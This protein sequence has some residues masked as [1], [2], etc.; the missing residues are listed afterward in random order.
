MAR[1]PASVHAKLL[2]AF[3]VI[4]GLLVTVSAVGRVLG[5]TNRRAEELVILHRKIAAYRQ[6]Q[7]DTTGQLYSVTSTLALPLEQVDVRMIE[8][9]LRQ[10]KQFGYDLDRLQY[11]AKDEAT[12]LSRIQEE[13]NRFIQVMSEAITMIA[14][15][16]SPLPGN[17]NVR[18][19]RPWLTAWS[20][21]PTSW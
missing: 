1:L 10:L 8:A 18:R 4:A 16:G 17:C 11:V 13:Y 20:A 14:G 5:E 3:L 2:V 7:H 9:A 21:S 12:L 19:P 6:L 15:G